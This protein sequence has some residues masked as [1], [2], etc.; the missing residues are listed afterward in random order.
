[1]MEKAGDRNIKLDRLEETKMDAQKSQALASEDGQV[2]NVF[3]P[4]KGRSMSSNDLAEC[5]SV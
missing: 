5:N 3:Q 2:N 1:M 4:V